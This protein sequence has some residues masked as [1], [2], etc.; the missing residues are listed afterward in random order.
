MDSTPVQLTTENIW[1]RQPGENSR[2]YDRF[3]LYLSIG[4]SRSIHRTWQLNLE[5]VGK[6]QIRSN[7]SPTWYQIA[8][9]FRWHERAEEYDVYRRLQVFTQGNAHDLVRINKLDKVA[10]KLYD[11]VVNMLDS[12]KPSKGGFSELMILRLNETLDAGV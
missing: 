11:K 8:N 9:K 1:D 7:I 4:P 5:K 10:E 3:C 2:W 12:M 6:G